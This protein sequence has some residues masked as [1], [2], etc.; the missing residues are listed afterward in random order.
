MSDPVIDLLELFKEKGPLS[1]GD[2]SQ[3]LNMPKYKAL[4]MVSCLS[5]M[6]LLEPL[7]IKGSYKIYKISLA[8][9]QF[10]E[11]AEKAG[12]AAAAMEELLLTQQPANESQQEKEAATA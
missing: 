5:S 7:Y 6:G 4:A 10:L 1:P 12:T 8:G 9:Q 3:Q 2:V 11:R